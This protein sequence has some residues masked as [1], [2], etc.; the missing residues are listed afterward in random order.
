M[1]KFSEIATLGPGFVKACAG[2]AAPWD[3]PEIPIVKEHEQDLLL[4][5]DP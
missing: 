4:A 5:L 2:L 3:R 1:F